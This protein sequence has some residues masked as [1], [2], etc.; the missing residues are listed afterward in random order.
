M[1]LGEAFGPAHPMGEVT[2]V[3][4]DRLNGEI[5]SISELILANFWL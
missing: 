5:G 1:T 4:I 2:T 3:D